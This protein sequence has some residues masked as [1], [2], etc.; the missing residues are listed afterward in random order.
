[1]ACVFILLSLFTSPSQARGG[2]PIP[3]AGISSQVLGSQPRAL[4]AVV[5][6]SG[7]GDPTHVRTTGATAAGATAAGAGATATTAT[8]TATA[9]ATATTA[10]TATATATTA[11]GGGCVDVDQRSVKRSHV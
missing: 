1:M 7:R 4:G 6:L 8:T 2:A 3:R 9:T 5:F 11:V 10:P